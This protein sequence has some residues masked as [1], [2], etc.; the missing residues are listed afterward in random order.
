VRQRQLAVERAEYECA[1]AK[2]LTDMAQAW[3]DAQH[4]RAFLAAVEDGVPTEQDRRLPS[5]AF[6][7]PTHRQPADSSPTHR[8]TTTSA[9][10]TVPGWTTPS[11]YFA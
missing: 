11:A 10:D 5:V 9:P 4:I 7:E 8:R 6:S 2:D 3:T 1:L